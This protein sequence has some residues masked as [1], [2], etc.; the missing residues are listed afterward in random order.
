MSAVRSPR[1]FLCGLFIHCKCGKAVN[2]PGKGAKLVELARNLL[3]HGSESDSREAI[4][5]LTN[6]IVSIICENCQLRTE[7]SYVANRVGRG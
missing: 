3:G 7:K 6:K 4:S 1:N 2:S 5:W